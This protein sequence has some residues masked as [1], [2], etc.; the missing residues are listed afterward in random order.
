MI[1]GLTGGIASGKSTVLKMLADLGS[2][3]IDADQIS[4]E[5]TKK[6]SQALNEIKEVFG[7]EYIDKN[8]KLKREALG[9]EIFNDKLAKERLEQILHPKIDIQMKY[10]IDKYQ[11]EYPSKLIVVDIPLLYEVG[12]EEQFNEVWVVWVDFKTQ[13]ERLMKRNDLSYKEAKNRVRAQMPLDEK[14]KKADRVI[15]NSGSIN[16]TNRQVKELFNKVSSKE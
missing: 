15:D 1:I 4:R 11:K 5:A 6:G 14:R 12:K 2:I 16:H 10:L 3:T 13:L 7:K 8:G 9:D